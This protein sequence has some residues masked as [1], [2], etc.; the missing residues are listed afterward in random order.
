[1]ELCKR[2]DRSRLGRVRLGSTVL[3][4]ALAIAADAADPRPV[5]VIRPQPALGPVTNPLKGWCPYTNAGPI[6]LP[7]SM[8][9]HYV[10][11]RE[12]EPVRG[13][14]AFDAWER[15]A[16]DVPAGRGKHVVFRVYVDYPGKPSGLPDWLKD[17]VQQSPYTE[18][19]GGR[20]P[21]YANPELITG[22]ERL[23]AALGN[24]YDADPRV[25]F[26]ELGLL[27]FWGE[28]HTWPINR[29]KPPVATEQRVIDAYHAAFPT[30]GLMARLA[31]DNAGKR[32]WLGFHDDM[33]PEDTDNGHDWSFLAQIRQSG[34]EHNWKRAP[35]GGE[36]VPGSAAKWV[37]LG[38]DFKH[39]QAMID[40]SHFSWVGPYCPA[41]ARLPEDRRTRLLFIQQAEALVRQMGYEFRWREVRIPTRVEVGRPLAVELDGNNDGVAPFLK[42]WPVEVALLPEVG[43]PAARVRLAADVRSWLP[44]PIAVRESVTLTAPAGSYRFALGIVDPLTGEPAVGFGNQGEVR[45]GWFVF[46]P[47]EVTPSEAP[48]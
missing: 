26:V 19:G 34:R 47:L 39:T 1:M 15:R 30:L 13:V 2:S 35:I 11:W 37:N 22:L 16:W 5:Q 12:L 32:D 33:F 8:V 3:L 41:L 28:W 14:Y 27:G 17:S 29:L 9:Y 46:G 4:A 40:R 36:M 43:P 38:P 45:N 20:S 42:G 10:S 21:D 48:R 25:A 23:I 44:G 31:R 24:R 6:T 18:H 7:Y